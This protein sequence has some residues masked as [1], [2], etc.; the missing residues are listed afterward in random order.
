LAHIPFFFLELHTTN[1]ELQADLTNRDYLCVTIGLIHAM[2]AIV[3]RVRGYGDSFRYSQTPGRDL[4]MFP[5]NEKTPQG[6]QTKV[7]EFHSQIS[8]FFYKAKFSKTN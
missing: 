1:V 6:C 2:D 5:L 7:E 8:T 4:V 3:P